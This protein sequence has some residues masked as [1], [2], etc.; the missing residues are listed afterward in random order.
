MQGN[1]IRLNLVGLSRILLT[2]AWC[3]NEL[4]LR[5][6]HGQTMIAIINADL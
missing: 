2:L 6:T 1:R 3:F 4:H 5:Q